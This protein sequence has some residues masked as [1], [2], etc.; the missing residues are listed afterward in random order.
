M[1]L[2]RLEIPFALKSDGSR[3][4]LILNSHERDH[5]F[6]TGG[7]GS[8]KS[9]LISGIVKALPILPMEASAEAWYVDAHTFPEIQL[10]A[11]VRC[12][13]CGGYTKNLQTCI[14]ELHLESRKRIESYYSAGDQANGN[15]CCF[16]HLIVIISDAH[17]FDHIEDSKIRNMFEE[18]LRQSHLTGIHVFCESQVPIERID[19]LNPLQYYFNNRIVLRS[20]MELIYEALGLREKTVTE[21][22]KDVIQKLATGMPGDMIFFSRQVESEQISYGRVSYIDRLL[23]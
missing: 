20:N 18:L 1:V 16:S 6:I 7:V 8:G 17:V 5:V 12:F 19:T 23:E 22:V 11:H 3:I 10:D 2:K 9:N 14:E 13:L 15:A 4:G 21:P